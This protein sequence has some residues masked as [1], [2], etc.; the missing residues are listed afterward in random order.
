MIMSGAA[1]RCSALVTPAAALDTLKAA[2]AILIPIRA[3]G[4]SITV[5]RR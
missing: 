1:Y 4:R 2:G 5:R 3:R